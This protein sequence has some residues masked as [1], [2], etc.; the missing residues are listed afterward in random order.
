MKMAGTQTAQVDTQLGSAVHQSA[1]LSATGQLERLFSRLFRGLVYAQIWEDPIADMEAL[2]IRE[3]EDIVCIGSGGCNVMS[4]LTARPGSITAV[5]LSPAHVALIRL[6]LAAARHL[7]RYLT[8][9]DMFGRG[10]RIA[11]V[12]AYD[13]YIAPYLDPETRAYW[14]TRTLR[15][16]RIS[17]LSRGLYRQGVLGRFLRLVQMLAR[18]LG[19]KLEDALRAATPEAQKRVFDRQI[20]PV[21]DHPL[22]RLLARRRA[23]LFGLGIP[24]AQ[25][26]K[27]AADGDGDVIPVLRERARKLFCDFPVSENYFLCRPAPAAMAAGRC[28][29]TCNA[30]PSTR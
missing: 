8:F 28:R 9:F 10:D 27:L 1:A 17:L 12:E 22:V 18:I 13:R 25:H 23:A 29:P 20:A 24:P 4:Y 11:N 30:G 5:D 3:G 21:F 6:K 16:R 14:E 19:V 15:G 7:P 2:N 26:D